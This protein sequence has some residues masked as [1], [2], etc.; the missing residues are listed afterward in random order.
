MRYVL[1]YLSRALSWNVL[2]FQPDVTPQRASSIDSDDLVLSGQIPGGS[3]LRYCNESSKAD[4]YQI[5]DIE[6]YPNPLRM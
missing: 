4:L 3:P 2:L 6:L 5:E 1:D